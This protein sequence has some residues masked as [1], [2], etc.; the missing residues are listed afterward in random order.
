MSRKLLKDLRSN[1]LGQSRGDEKQLPSDKAFLDD[2]AD[3]SA[4]WL[5][6]EAADTATCRGGRQRNTT[7]VGRFKMHVLLKTEEDDGAGAADDESGQ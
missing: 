4:A 5:H 7:Q 1:C 3:V 2:S 6:A